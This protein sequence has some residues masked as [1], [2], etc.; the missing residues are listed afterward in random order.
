MRSIRRGSAVRLGDAISLVLVGAAVWIAACQEVDVTAVDVMHVEVSP[1]TATISIGQQRQLTATLRDAAGNQLY[2]RVVNWS[3][4]N[5]G[6]ASV[7]LDGQVR[8]VG[9]G[10]TRVTA[11]SGG[12][13]GTATISV[14]LPVATVEV[15]P[16]SVGL[17]VSESRQLQAVARRTDGTTAP[18]LPVA[19]VSLNGTI[20]SVDGT[21]RVTGNAVG[22]TRV[23]ATVEGKVGEASVAVAPD[24]VATVEVV[25]PTPSVAERRSI[26]L[27][28]VLRN[29]AGAVITGP[30]PSWTSSDTTTATVDGTGRVTGVRPGSATITATAQGKSGSAAIIVTARPV[31]RVDVMPV[32]TEIDVRETAQLVATART[33]GDTVLLRRSFAWSS[34]DPAVVSV[35]A[36][37]L[38]GVV[39]GNA[40]G[41][42]TITATTDGRSGTA[43]VTV[44]S[45]ATVVIRPDTGT[46][47]V[48]DSLGLKAETRA[49]NGRVLLNRVITWSTSDAAIATVV[50]TT[51]SD[52]TLVTS[53]TGTVTITATSEGQSGTAKFTVLRVPPASVEVLPASATVFPG[54]TQLY[55]ATVKSATGAVLT[56]WPVTWTSDNPGTATVLSSSG[57]TFTATATAIDAPCA[58]GEQSCP[59]TISATVDTASQPPPVGV[60]GSATLTVLKPVTSVAI[61]PG[62]VVLSLALDNNEQ[63]TATLTAGDGTVLTGRRVVWTSDDT[64]VATVDTTGLVTAVSIGLANITAMAEGKTAT[65]L[66]TAGPM[67]D[68]SEPPLSQE[69]SVEYQ[70]A[71]RLGPALGQASGT[72]PLPLPDRILNRAQPA[73]LDATAPRAR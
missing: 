16:S 34:D 28:T 49:A 55:Q 8:G 70:P 39:T 73:A 37:G 58:P 19:W 51:G 72:Y 10:T 4:E 36:Q 21:G 5:D 65:V 64:L 45:V 71:T 22:S 18:G 68:A 6:I 69:A 2:G 62:V 60:T 14:A 20:A 24:S 46:L 41:Q 1:S 11:S 42:V 29:A 3:T 52:V 57:T 67:P 59:V 7:T 56:Y 25:P 38:L 47:A 27:Q 30:T 43:T 26:T 13:S 31:V 32:T 63:L 35:P 33:N 9:T 44:P 50:P 40:S 54:E 48:G 12:R 61:S 23:T 15:T 53:D 17:R 66:V